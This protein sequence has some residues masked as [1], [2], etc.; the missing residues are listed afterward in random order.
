[1]S[2]S[3]REASRTAK[4]NVGWQKDLFLKSL[5]R[6]RSTFVEYF[7]IAGFDPL[8]LVD[9]GNI[10]DYQTYISMLYYTSHKLMNNVCYFFFVFS[11][12]H[13][14]SYYRVIKIE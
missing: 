9:S 3:G 10:L 1:M 7:L 5:Q 8:T 13:L 12:L 2:I 4:G 14:F 11:R 6:N